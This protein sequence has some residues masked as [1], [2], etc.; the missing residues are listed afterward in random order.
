VKFSAPVSVM[1]MQSSWRTPSS[2]G[3]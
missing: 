2:P 1:K 3:M